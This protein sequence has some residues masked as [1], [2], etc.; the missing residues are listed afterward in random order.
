[1]VQLILVF[2]STHH[3]IAIEQA[4]ANA[5]FLR[6]VIPIPPSIQAGCGMAVRIEQ[7]DCGVSQEAAMA[8]LARFAK[9]AGAKAQV[10][11]EHAARTAGQTVAPKLQ[12]DEVPV[13]LRRPPIAYEFIGWIGD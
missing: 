1:M 13:S 4:L 11:V 9:E 5:G 2:D 6:A 3:A 10:F 7:D 8:T 12:G